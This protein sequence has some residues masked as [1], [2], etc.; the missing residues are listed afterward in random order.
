MGPTQITTLE[1]TKVEYL[2]Y[3]PEM[4][5]EP[6]SIYDHPTTCILEGFVCSIRYKPL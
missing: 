6:P 1:D 2:V 4:P 3:V 5:H